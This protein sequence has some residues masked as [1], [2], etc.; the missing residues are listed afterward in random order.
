VTLEQGRGREVRFGFRALPGAA[1]IPPG[2]GDSASF[3][4]DVTDGTNV[5]A[6]RVR[7]P[8]RPDYHPRSYTIAG[9]LM[10]TAT[11]VFTL[12]AGIDPDRSRLYLSVGPSPLALVRAAY[13]QME[14]YPYDCSEQVSSEARVLIALYQ[15]QRALGKTIPADSIVRGDPKREIEK[16]VEVLSARQRSDGGIGYWSSTDW[17]TPWLSAYAGAVLVDAKSVGVAV[18]DSVMARLA[19]YLGDAMRAPK[20]LNVPV[21]NYYGQR[22]TAL[23]D[24]VAAADLLSRMGKPDLPTENSLLRNAAQMSF[25][26]RL[27]LA[28]MIARRGDLKTARELMVPAWA[29]V[30]VEGRKATLPDSVRT[31]FYF[32]SRMRP[33]ARLLVATVMI[34]KTNRLIAPMVETLAQISGAGANGWY[35]SS[36]DL[37]SAVSA[38][39]TYEQVTNGSAPR[40]VR[41]RGGAG[42]QVLLDAAAKNGPVAV[43]VKPG[44]SPV[45]ISRLPR[46]SSL[47]LHGLL[48]PAAGETRPLTLTLDSPGET[49]QGVA[50][51]FL[52]VSEVPLKRPVTPDQAGIQVERWYESFDGG[53]PTV[54]VAEGDLVRVR[55]RITVPTDREFVVLDDALPAGLEAVD[56]SLRTSA[57]GA[58]PGSAERERQRGE[59]QEMER[60]GGGENWWYYGWW[61]GGW[62]SPFDHRELRD[63]RVVYFATYLWR[64]TYTASYIA[65]ATTPGVF[66][67]P[68]A[69]AEE[70]YNPAVHG[71]SDGG[72]FT[73]TKKSP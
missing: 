26:D 43:V 44:T 35:W 55:L 3:R 2:Q 52:T 16:A 72:L 68:P 37:A 59:D 38:L 69:H 31:Y 21:S 27:R 71:R 66:V 17:T 60:E 50:Y 12:P 42:N 53:K 46:D 19:R 73:V 51:Y 62:W 63:D 65:R 28:E 32:S 57:I 15:A 61:D 10:D 24:Q 29:M 14:V 33:M 8:I 36:Q 40:R 11:A 4:F 67:R 6:V 70:M 5:D 47:S 41:V 22:W 64:G 39:A 9:V 23:G 56:L 18:D 13:W 45:P 7:V 30:T 25:E 58:G 34:D 20:T 54:S 1:S 48:G 49:S